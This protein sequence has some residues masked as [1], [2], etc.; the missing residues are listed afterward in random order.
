MTPE[1]IEAREMERRR[2]IADSN[3][4]KAKLN[5]ISSQDVE[6][7]EKRIDTMASAIRRGLANSSAAIAA[8]LHPATFQNW[9]NYAKQGKEP[10]ASLWWKIQKAK[11][12]GKLVLA[13]HVYKA[14][15]RDWKAAAWL[16]ERRAKEFQRPD[17]SKPHS[18]TLVQEVTVENSKKQVEDKLDR[19]RQLREKYLEE[20]SD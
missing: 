3:R 5:R 16:L 9:K 6:E 18:T 14:A 4:G 15:E 8:G 13:D 19:I 10:Y 1:E 17:H 11:E 2:K 12:E 20:I 7:I